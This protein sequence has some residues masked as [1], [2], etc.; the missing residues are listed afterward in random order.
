MKRSTN[1]IRYAI[2][3]R[4]SS[5]SEDRQEQSLV[6]QTTDLQRVIDREGLHIACAPFQESQTAFKIGR[7]VFQEL[8][9]RTLD[10]EITG[11]VCWHSNRLSRNPV[12]AGM[13]IHLMDQGFLKEIRTFNGVYTNSPAHK[14]MLAFEFGI[15]KNDSEEKS[16][17]VRSGMRRRYERGF[18]SG[19]PPVGFM[20]ST[21]HSVK[22][23]TLWQPDPERLPLVR[24]I[25]R[26]FLE[27]KDSLSSITAYARRIGLQTRPRKNQP[28]GYLRRSSVHRMLKN[29]VYSGVFLGPENEV[30]PL[31][32]TLPRLI[33]QDEFDKI[34]FIL[35]DRYVS[36]KEGRRL[37]AFSGLVKSPDGEI[38]SVDPKFHLVCDCNKKFCYLNRK[39]CPHCASEISKLR[40]PRYRSYRYYFSPR[41]KRGVGRWIR[42]IEEKKIRGLLAD[43]I[44]DNLYL[45]KELLTW[46]LSF[47]QEL[48]DDILR[49]RQ[50]E[51]RER[52]QK[53]KDV[54]GKR[55]RLNDM[56]IDGQ[57]TKEDYEARMAEFSVLEKDSEKADYTLPND[58]KA[59]GQKIGDLAEELL[60]LLKHGE[61]REIND[62]L[63]A[64]GISMIWDG[65][66]LSFTHTET[67][68]RVLR[69]FRKASVAGRLRE[70]PKKRQVRQYCS[71]SL[72]VE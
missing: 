59:E 12:D 72:D 68:D 10:G 17:I 11:W 54:E 45:P 65:Q 38:L 50:R 48:Q 29:P 23:S 28:P 31:E 55:Q 53:L 24:R 30:Y 44:R 69:L 35:G 63:T 40:H 27:G 15:S 4:K 60:L 67:L 37:Y 64:I 47:I 58:W 70:V 20:L 1:P 26:K 42:A 19:H 43:H 21:V 32:K 51:S 18:P 52:A 56:R 66:E 46:S 8:V 34:R 62:A 49:N 2:Y 25:F 39:V 16:V 9:Q 41:A 33:T 22:E 36:R 5:D 14:L 6:R 3:V 13:V 71:N 61:D 57:I 7:P